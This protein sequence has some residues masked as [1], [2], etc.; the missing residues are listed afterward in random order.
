[1]IQTFSRIFD[2]FLT[3]LPRQFIINFPFV[4]RPGAQDMHCHCQ[5]ITDHVRHKQQSFGGQT[6]MDL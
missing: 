5:A 4:E 2:A 3:Q 6:R 1:M